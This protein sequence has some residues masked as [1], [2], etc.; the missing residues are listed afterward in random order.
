[1]STL[2][3][4]EFDKL[5]KKIVSK[6][7][8]IDKIRPRY[9]PI[10]NPFLCATAKITIPD[11]YQRILQPSR[12]LKICGQM[13][14]LGGYDRA[15][16]IVLN[17]KFEVVDGQHRLLALLMRGGTK[18]WVVIYEFNTFEDEVTYWVW[19]QKNMAPP[20]PDQFW[21]SQY[22]IK[23][24]YSVLI[25]DLCQNDV[26]SICNNMVALKTSKAKKKK[27]T[28]AVFLPILNQMGLKFSHSSHW[29]QDNDHVFTNKIKEIGYQEIKAR[30]NA[31]FTWFITIYGKSKFNNPGY[32]K[33]IML[34]LI[35]VFK[36]MYDEGHL[37]T[38]RNYNYS[39]RKMQGFNYSAMKV[40]KGKVDDY[41]SG[42]IKEYSEKRSSKYR[43][44]GK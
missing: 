19:A 44:D 9:K 25:Y 5:Q 33:P 1:M 8:G 18:I 37:K 31:F 41:E 40:A 16:P 38:K 4:E 42:F 39:V 30:M 12:V 43:L 29:S 15:K 7:G 36:R 10:R 32:E 22:L 28:L 35:R 13:D 24:P 34:A 17:E 2:S 21:H 26:T 14:V 6:F 20:G 23:N 3:Q 27:I 11:F